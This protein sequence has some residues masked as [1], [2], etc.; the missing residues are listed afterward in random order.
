MRVRDGDTVVAWAVIDRDEE[1][2]EEDGSAEAVLEVPLPVEKP[3]DGSGDLNPEEDVSQED[4]R[5]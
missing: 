4:G 3:E 2:G 1:E 5:D